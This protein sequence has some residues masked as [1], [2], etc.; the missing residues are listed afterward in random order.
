MAL[1]KLGAQRIVDL[2]DD[3]PNARH[4]NT[5]FEE[6]VKH[7][8]R[9][10]AWNF[11]ILRTVLAPTA[12]PIVANPDLPFN[13]AFPL[14]ADCLRILPPSRINVDWQ[15]EQIDGVSAIFT[16]DGTSLSIRYVSYVI[17]PNVWDALFAEAVA[18]KIAVQVCEAITQSNTKQE[19]AER[20]YVFAI[21][22]ARQIN[23]FENP[24]P[25]EP[26][27]MWV[28]VRHAGALGTRNWLVG[29]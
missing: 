6:V 21:R 27:D 15:I 7:E 26:E 20:E 4:I 17:N 13:N 14:P 8:L 19:K 2:A 28:N 1:Q 25:D 11:S 16:N 5:C 12:T 9:A 23:A 3:N 10:H 29:G 18:C 24:T 22:R